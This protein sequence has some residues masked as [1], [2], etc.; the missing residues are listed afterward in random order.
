MKQIIKVNLLYMDMHIEVLLENPEGQMVLHVRKPE[1]VAA[2]KSS[3]WYHKKLKDPLLTSDPDLLYPNRPYIW[4]GEYLTFHKSPSEVMDI[5]V[6]PELF[7]KQLQ[8]LQGKDRA[9]LDLYLNKR[10]VQNLI[11]DNGGHVPD[12]YHSVFYK[13]DRWS[14]PEEN[15]F[16]PKH[17]FIILK[18]N[19]SHCVIDRANYYLSEPSP[20]EIYSFHVEADPEEIVQRWEAYYKETK[21]KANPLG[22]N[23]AVV[24]QWFL[25]N[26][27]GVDN[28]HFWNA[29]FSYDHLPQLSLTSLGDFYWPSMIPSPVT[30]PKR[31]F[32]HAKFQKEIQKNTKTLAGENT[33]LL[34]LTLAQDALFIM[35]NLT[36][37]YLAQ[38]YLDSGLDYARI[39]LHAVVEIKKALPRFFASATK[40]AAHVQARKL[41]EPAN[42]T[43]RESGFSG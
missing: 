42:T 41:T 38:N 34:G 1:D 6:N 5:P 2:M 26:F 33:C 36:G 11:T 30:L 19:S 10:Q 23:C 39:T 16:V 4:D 35:G 18:M 29:P 24:T 9:N 8:D 3:W 32:E 13:I 25:S 15:G 40:Y 22:N 28:P 12:S 37:L 17:Q 14:K 31:I 27:C 43:E 21:A 20:T 7:D